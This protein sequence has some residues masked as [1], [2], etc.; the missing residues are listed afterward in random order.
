M[1]STTRTAFTTLVGL[2]AV[3]GF[4][5]TLR[6]ET[7][8][9]PRVDRLVLRS[10]SSHWEDKLSIDL[11]SGRAKLLIFGIN[12]ESEDGDPPGNLCSSRKQRERCQPVTVFFAQ[13]SFL[14]HRVPRRTPRELSTSRI[15]APLRI[16]VEY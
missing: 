9:P 4:T 6:A 11:K 15:R 2:L 10:T 3:A 7:R 16:N 8:R 13:C 5:M 14:F 1:T 12:V